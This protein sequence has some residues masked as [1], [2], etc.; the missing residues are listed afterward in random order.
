VNNTDKK[1]TETNL[2]PIIR[3]AFDVISFSISFMSPAIT[4]VFSFF[5][6]SVP[7]TSKAPH[8]LP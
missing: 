1:K 5:S 3:G 4:L 7:A 2:I 8:L 6:V